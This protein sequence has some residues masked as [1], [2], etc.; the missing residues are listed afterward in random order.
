MVAHIATR[1][2]PHRWPDLFASLT[3]ISQRGDAH[4]E[5]ALM[6]LRGLADGLFDEE[7]PPRLA[8]PC[9]PQHGPPPSAALAILPTRLIER[10][11]LVCCQ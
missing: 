10:Y 2:W 8:P 9:L 6:V 5:L 11:L 1:E 7:A 4:S 3:L